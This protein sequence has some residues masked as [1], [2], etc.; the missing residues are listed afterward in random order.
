MKAL[1][2]FVALSGAVLLGWI[3]VQIAAFIRTATFSP[4]ADFTTQVLLIP[5]P[6]SLR[7]TMFYFNATLGGLLWVVEAGIAVALIVTGRRILAHERREQIAEKR[8]IE[9]IV[10]DRHGA[11]AQPPDNQIW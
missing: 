5:S 9:R 1:G 3:A 8:A 10:A 2:I 11:S 7:D 4:D 6:E